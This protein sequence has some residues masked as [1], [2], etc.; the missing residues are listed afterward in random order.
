[1]IWNI[2]TREKS[3]V[4]KTRVTETDNVLFADQSSI[5]YFTHLVK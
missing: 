5:Q 1:M 2:S 4:K 3:F